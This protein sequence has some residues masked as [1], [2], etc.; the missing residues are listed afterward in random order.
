MYIMTFI[1]YLQNANLINIKKLNKL[2]FPSMTLLLLVTIVSVFVPLSPLMP[3][4]NLDGSWR[5]SLN[6]AFAQGLAFGDEI[7]FQLGPYASIW[8][9]VYH[10]STDFIM[11]LGS[12]YLALSY[13]IMLVFLM[14]GINWRW[15]IFYGRYFHNSQ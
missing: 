7:V 8:T 15:I 12:S 9:T 6:Q 10:P 5:F 11:L 13:F 14:I 2:V 3:W 4:D 1:E